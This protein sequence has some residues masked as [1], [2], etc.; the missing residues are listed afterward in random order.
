MKF[1]ELSERLSRQ[2]VAAV[3]KLRQADLFKPSGIAET[4]GWGYAVSA[5]D[6]VEL[7]EQTINATLGVLLKYHDDVQRV[8]ELFSVQLI[9]ESSSV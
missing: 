3:Q 6:H 8:K 2:I 7:D 4:L 5:M 9:D 1:P